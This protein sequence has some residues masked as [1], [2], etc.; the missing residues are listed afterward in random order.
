MPIEC[1]P[2]DSQAKSAI[3]YIN[4]LIKKK[5]KN[6]IIYLTLNIKGLSLH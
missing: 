6:N 3:E 2:E 4:D 5:G 1:P